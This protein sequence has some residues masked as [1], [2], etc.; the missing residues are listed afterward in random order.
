VLDEEAGTPITEPARE[1]RLPAVTLQW[2]TLQPWCRALVATSTTGAD[3][4][5]SNQFHRAT[6]ALT[7]QLVADGYVDGQPFDSDTATIIFRPGPV[8]TFQTAPVLGHLLGFSAVFRHVVTATRD[9]YG[10]PV[11]EFTVTA[12]MLTG[13]PP[14]VIQDSL[15]SSPVEAAGT[16]RLTVG[17][18][19]RVIP[20][21]AVQDLRGTWRLEWACHGLPAAEAGGAPTDSVHYR[22]DAEARFGG[23]TGRGGFTRFEGTLF[24]REWVRGQPVREAAATDQVRF[25]AQR[26]ALLEWS[27]GEVAAAVGPGAFAGGSLCEPLPDGRA[28]AGFTPA[29]VSRR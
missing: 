4:T 8:V 21:W 6:P 18:A 25:A 27:P 15:V 26:P 16:L 24:T 3:G 13:A 23:L 29:R 17:Q 19:S 14:F 11:P 20:V 10:N 2:R 7:C 9:A 1:V 12:E 28:W 5:A 22:L